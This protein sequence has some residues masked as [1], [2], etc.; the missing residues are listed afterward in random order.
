M[1]EVERVTVGEVTPLGTRLTPFDTDDILLMRRE[2]ALMPVTTEA[3]DYESHARKSAREQWAAEL[4][5]T[6]CRMLARKGPHGEVV[7]G[8][9]AYLVMGPPA[10]G[11]SSAITEP[12]A[13]D[14]G[15][16]LIDADEAKKK[17]PEYENG[18]N[19]NGV[20]EESALIMEGMVL[21]RA[22]DHGDNIVMPLVGKNEAKLR[23]L[24]SLLKDE[25]YTVHL[26]L[27]HV[28]REE[29]TRR[30]VARFR[31]TGRFVDP[32]YVYD[33]VGD[34]RWRSMLHS[35][36]RQTM[37][38]NRRARAAIKQTRTHS[39][40]TLDRPAPSRDP[41]SPSYDRDEVVLDYALATLE[42]RKAARDARQ[43]TA[44]E[45]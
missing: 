13:R 2:V 9:V 37:P 30:A 6:D 33:E 3:P 17:I 24:T 14:A 39:T 29:A 34:S 32:H 22:L 36:R 44:R 43:Q 19:A 27:V 26:V 35:R 8:R 41:R 11:K 16:L 38:R 25:G 7:Q 42:R 31:V 45:A 23:A 21:D 40:T 18:R 28:D 4:Y 5:T 10:A 1:P 15:A 20:H 12:L